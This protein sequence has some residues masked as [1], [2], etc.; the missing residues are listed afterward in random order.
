[1]LPLGID[2]SR[3]QRRKEQVDRVAANIV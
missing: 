1:M 3:E 2:Y